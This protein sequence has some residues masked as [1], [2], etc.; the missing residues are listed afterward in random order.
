M[1][2]Y[3]N[4]A[5][6]NSVADETSLIVQGTVSTAMVAFLQQAVLRMVP[7][8]VPTIVL[9]ALDLLYGCRAAKF[10][11]EKIRLSTAIRRTT[12]KFFGYVCWLIL[13][14]TLAIAFDK[15]WLEWGTLGLVYANELLSVIGNYLETKGVTLSIVGVYRWFIKWIAGK[16]GTEMSDDDA[17]DI[18]K[19]KNKNKKKAKDEAGGN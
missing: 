16:A 4:V 15:V 11:G 17:A 14:T 5:I 18:V 12:T 3:G 9:I 13:A 19:N 8:A 7:Y 6:A 2:K 10:R 1:F